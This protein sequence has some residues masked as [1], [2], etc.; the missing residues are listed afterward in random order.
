MP[1]QKKEKPVS[2]VGEKEERMYEHI[3]ESAEKSGRYK[4]REK[5]V[6]ARTVRKH[7]KQEGH[8]KGQ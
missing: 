1:G 4:G 8:Q 7:H 5:E 2:G 3:K 6:A